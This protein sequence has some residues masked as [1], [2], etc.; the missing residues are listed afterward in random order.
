MAWWEFVEEKYQQLYPESK[1]LILKPVAPQLA[2]DAAVVL[3]PGC[4]IDLKGRPDENAV[5]TLDGFNDR[6]SS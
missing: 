3:H 4:Q 5:V 6:E 2:T 1:S